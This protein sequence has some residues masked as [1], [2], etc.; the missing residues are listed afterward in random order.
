MSIERHERK[1]WARSHFR[2]IENLLVPS[3][4]P[5]LHD[6]DER[7]LALDVEQSIRHGFFST[8][9]ALEAGLTTAEQKRLVRAA[10]TCAGTRIGVS[11]SLAGESIA[12]NVET[13]RWAED[14]GI[15]HAHLSFP[16]HFQPRKEEDVHAF[17]DGIATQTGVALCLPASDRFA[18][19]HLHPSG[20]PFNAYERLADLDNV[21]ALTITGHDSGMLLE[22]CERFSDR[23][24]VTTTNLS[25]LPMLRQNF[26]VQWTGAWGAEA[27]QSPAARHAVEVMELLLAGRTE[28]AMA[29]YW[30]LTP[31][32]A[33]MLRLTAGWAASGASHWPMLKYQQWLSG[34]NGGLTRQPCMRMFDRDMQAIR[35]ALRAVG[36]ECPDRDEAFYSGRTA[37]K[38][39]R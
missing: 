26:N 35:S 32:L 24:L 8:C 9:C 19:H 31:A 10:T 14:A 25:M 12:D 27:L 5:D 29:I 21:V 18:L 4:T 2:G 15:T 34:G 3:F 36:V 33:T 11:V 13:L 30:K 7:A 1:A 39:A 20:V 22:C 38:A 23:L 16:Q 37:Q 28:A 6:L 17:V